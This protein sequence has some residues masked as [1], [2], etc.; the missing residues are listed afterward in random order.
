ML[1]VRPWDKHE[2]GTG[3]PQSRGI[4]V[5]KAGNDIHFRQQDNGRYCNNEVILHR[6]VS[7]IDIE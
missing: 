6:K 7:I 3:G 2:R 1:S 5:R 4:V